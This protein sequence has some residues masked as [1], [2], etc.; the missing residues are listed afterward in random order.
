MFANIVYPLLIARAVININIY[1]AKR[2]V[3]PRL[4]HFAS[5]TLK[6]ATRQSLQSFGK[7]RQDVEP[8][9]KG[10]DRRVWPPKPVSR[11]N[12]IR[13]FFKVLFQHLLACFEIT[14]L[15]SNEA[16]HHYQAFDY[17]KLASQENCSLS[18]FNCVQCSR[19]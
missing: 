13:V 11:N 18:C 14:K 10:Q 6:I 7:G 5:P 16:T 12:C 17:C 4:V 2:P 9:L 19:R 8:A 1:G 3:P 15:D